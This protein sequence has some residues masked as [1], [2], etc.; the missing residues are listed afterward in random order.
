M[1][2]GRDALGIRA[3]GMAVTGAGLAVSGPTSMRDGGLRHECLG[4]VGR[5][6]G[7]ELLEAGH[8]ANLLEEHD[9]ARFVPIDTNPSTV[10]AAVLQTLE[11]SSE[12]FADGFAVL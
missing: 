2:A 5:R 10:V 1:Y 12:N 4:R 3:K 11:T 6:L 7:D 8:L 9:L